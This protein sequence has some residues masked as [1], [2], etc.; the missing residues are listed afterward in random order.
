MKRNKNN[1][2]IKGELRDRK[3]IK[4]QKESKEIVRE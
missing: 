3:I 1:E 4:R 2:E